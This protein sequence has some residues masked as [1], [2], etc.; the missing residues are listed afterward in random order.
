[1]ARKRLGELLLEQGAITAEQLQAGL[2]LQ[3]QSGN[4]LGAALVALGVLT[5]ERLVGALAVALSLETVNLDKLEVEWSALHALRDRFCDAN[6]LFPVSIEAKPT[7]RKVLT[8][9][10]ADPLNLAAVEEIEF[11]TGFKVQPKLATLS[12]VRN[13][14]RRHYLKLPPEEKK[15]APIPPPMP[16]ATAPPRPV[17][18]EVVLT[19][20]VIEEVAPTKPVPP[21]QRQISGRTDLA[22]LIRKR[23]EAVKKRA[24]PSSGG[25]P[26]TALESDLEYLVGE[27]MYGPD[28]YEQIDR[29]ERKLWALM[30]IMAKKGL[31]TRE[32]FLAE[33]ED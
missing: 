20:A 3:R 18:E 24:R 19:D 15:P 2:G 4:R 16:E 25:G 26:R 29:L 22:E 5:E 7:G 14:I 23:E 12:Q 31:L 33:F 28:A 21:P 11:T 1:M 6:D 30:R 17:S 13:A 9:A 8:V 10:M 32:E 27:P